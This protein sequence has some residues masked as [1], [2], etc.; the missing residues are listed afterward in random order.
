MHKKD[1]GVMHIS[2]G[3]RQERVIERKPLEIHIKGHTYTGKTTVTE[4]ISRALEA[5]GIPHDVKCLDGDLALRRAKE[6]VYPDS[7]DFL[8]ERASITII[9]NNE[10]PGK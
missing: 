1:H 9:D 6:G 5:H 4:I 2:V 8:K 10:R 7:V 3:P